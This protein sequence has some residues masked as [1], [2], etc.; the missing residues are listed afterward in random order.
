MLMVSAE[1]TFDIVRI[2]SFFILQCLTLLIVAADLLDN[3]ND[4]E[5]SNELAQKFMTSTSSARCHLIIIL[6]RNLGSA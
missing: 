3:V 6:H 2:C 4:L 5:S 1:V